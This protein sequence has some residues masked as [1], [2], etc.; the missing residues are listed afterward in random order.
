MFM[1]GSR[2]SFARA[3]RQTPS[4]ADTRLWDRL[5]GGKLDGLKFRRQHTADRFFPDFACY[6]LRLILEIDGGVHQRD[7][8]ILRDHLRQ[9]E[10]EASGWTVLRFTDVEALEHPD[11]VIAAI[12]QHVT[13][14]H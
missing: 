14:L 7:D 10:L 12:R 1:A 3:Q 9:V 11:R 2:T 6:Q 8:V 4:L 13:A 5:R